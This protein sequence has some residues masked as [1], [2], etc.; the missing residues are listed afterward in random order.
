MGALWPPSNNMPETPWLTATPTEDV[1]SQAH[2]SL[3][4]SGE[5]E[6]LFLNKLVTVNLSHGSQASATSN[7]NLG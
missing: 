5:S 1:M 6:S 4:N 2:Q 7:R 3:R